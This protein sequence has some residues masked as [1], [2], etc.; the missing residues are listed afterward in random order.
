MPIFYS[1]VLL[2]RCNC[3]V[4]PL[5]PNTAIKYCSEKI[6]AAF[7]YNTK[8]SCHVFWQA[9]FRNGI[10]RIMP[11]NFID[12]PL[13]SENTIQQTFQIMSYHR[14]AMQIERTGSFENAVHFDDSLCHIRQIR[15][16]RFAMNFT[17]AGNIPCQA[18]KLS[19]SES[20]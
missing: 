8:R 19:A 20:R 4:F 6:T 1:V 15:H 16:H 9:V 3:I 13:V 2:R 18:G 11:N 17:D 12:K 5:I 7:L 14:V 10:P